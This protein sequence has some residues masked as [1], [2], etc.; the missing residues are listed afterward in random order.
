MPFSFSGVK[1]KA[2]LRVLTLY[3]VR[4]MQPLSIVDDVHFRELIHHIDPRLSLPCSTLTHSLLPELYR[5]AK[6]KLKIK[7]SAVKWVALTADGWTSITNEGYL[8]VTVH[9]ISEK[10]KMVSRVLSTWCVEVSHTAENLAKELMDLVVEWQLT[11]KIVAV[12]TDNAYNIVKAVNE[13]NNWRHVPCF[14]HSLSLAVKDA[15]KKNKTL[16][17]KSNLLT[18]NFKTK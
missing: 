12:V 16:L 9:Y 10:M 14:A 1:M 11:G 13:I 7:L 8:T 6:A 5:E 3:I 4:S 2:F 15:I 18:I 17:R